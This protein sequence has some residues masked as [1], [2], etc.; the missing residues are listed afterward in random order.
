MGSGYNGHKI[1]I[2]A[3]I[4]ASVA[5]AKSK[6]D[7][8]GTQTVA[9]EA[10]ATATAIN[11][12]KADVHQIESIFMAA[13][14]STVADSDDTDVTD[15]FDLDTGQRDNFYDLGRLVRKS[16][17][18]APTGR[19]LVN[20][21]FFTHGAGNFFSVDSYSG[22][23]YGSIPAYTSDV[24]G[25]K[26]ELRDVLDF[27]PRVDN[28]STID[29]GDKD[30]TFD[31]TGASVIEV[32]KINTDVTADLEFHLAKKAR[33]YLTS[34]GLFRVIEGASSLEPQF[35][36]ELKDSIHLYD[37]EIPPFTFNTND[38]KIKAIDNRRFTMRDIGRIQRLSLI[39]I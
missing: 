33:V 7:T 31:G 36:E 34:S 22:F 4:S 17:A 3:T 15:R 25:E 16:T 20:F 14:F 26:F 1:K 2:L 30:R 24:T 27:R 10:L 39:H 5:G 9:T 37:V 18:L 28:A 21:K 38:V 8:A 13:D 11:L 29:S 6:T 35:P 19:L 23:D 32:M 12:G